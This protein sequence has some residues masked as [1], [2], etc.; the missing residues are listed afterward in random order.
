M[1]AQKYT[2]YYEGNLINVVGEMEDELGYSWTWRVV[3]RDGSPT[4]DHL[5]F[6]GLGVDQAMRYFEENIE[7]NADY[8]IRG[9]MWSFRQVE[10]GYLGETK[11][12]EESLVGVIRRTM[13]G[14]YGKMGQMVLRRGDGVG[15]TIVRFSKSGSLSFESTQGRRGVLKLD[16]R[17]LFLY[18]LDFKEKYPEGYFNMHTR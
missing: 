15:R 10:K 14:G 8:Y 9:W 11:R 13:E 6:P 3:T 16:L 5:V 1:G 4:P 17:D 2:L 12:A 7:I 18:P